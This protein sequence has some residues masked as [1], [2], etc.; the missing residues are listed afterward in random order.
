M[1]LNFLTAQTQLNSLALEKSFV[2]TATAT[3]RIL[4]IDA[5]PSVSASVIEALQQSGY[6]AT[7]AN[8]GGQAL[9][10]LGQAQIDL[11]VLDLGL[12]EQIGLK[13]LRQLRE[14]RR[15]TAIIV[16]T[17]HATAEGAIA[18]LKANVVDYIV[19]PYPT[20]DLL[21]TIAKAIEERAQQLRQQHLLNL[22][23][24]AFESLQPESANLP[25]RVSAH[26]SQPPDRACAGSIQL[27]LQKR[28]VTMTG[29]SA[30]TVELTES[31]M[32]IL[33]AMMEKPNQVLTYNQLGCALGYENMDKWT[34]ENVIRTVMFRLRQKIEDDSAK[35]KIIRTVR[36]RGYYFSPV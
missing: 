11:I 6:Q 26:P 29:E 15:D 4:V 3:P 7:T 1:A 31:E 33:T 20:G 16:T 35:G 18:A 24:Q 30:R 9:A 36:G 19:K 12:P 5:D 27:D 22:V 23:S 25:Q 28:Q 8:S 21:L 32:A 2:A 14:I 13:T 34:V 10:I 17:A